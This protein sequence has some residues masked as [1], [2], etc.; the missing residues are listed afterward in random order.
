[1]GHATELYPANFEPEAFNPAIFSAR[2]LPDRIHYRLVTC[3]TCDL[4]RSDPVI[5]AEVMA[6]LY[7]QSTFDYGDELAG[8]QQTYGRYLA[9]LEKYGVQ[10]GALLEVG[11]GNGF[12]LEEALR[13]GYAVARGVEPSTAAIEQAAPTVQPHIVCD[14]MR[15]GIFG[16]EQFDVVC[17]FQVFDH[18]PDPAALLKECYEVL[19]PGGYILFLN[20]NIEAFSARVLKEKSPIVDLEHT[21]L[22]SPQ[23]LDKIAAQHGFTTRE[24][25]AVRNTYSLYYLM[26][27]VPLPN[28][29]KKAALNLLKKSPLGRKLFSVPLGNLYLIAQK[30]KAPGS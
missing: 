30:G 1:M 23:T 21:Y 18:I 8:L 14:M 10:K 24:S 25:G 16:S 28:G 6:T 3:D 19:K 12:F 17:L 5:D 9:L 22:Y 13:Q 20:H 26:R 11:C 7:A 27:L 4:V 15:A 29:L 2:R